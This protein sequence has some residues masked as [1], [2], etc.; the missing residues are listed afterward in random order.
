MSVVNRA[1]CKSNNSDT[2][3]GGDLQDILNTEIS[4]LTEGEKVSCEGK[5]TIY[6]C[7]I[8]LKSMENNKYPGQMASISFC[9]N[10]LEWC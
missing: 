3:Q 7:E 9:I 4:L 5:L 10:F 1:K 6:E 8:A 2:E